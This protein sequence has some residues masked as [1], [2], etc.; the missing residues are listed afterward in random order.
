MSHNQYPLDHSEGSSPDWEA[1]SNMGRKRAQEKEMSRHKSDWRDAGFLTPAAASPVPP[2]APETPRCEKCGEMT[3]TPPVCESCKVAP[4]AVQEEA[5][6]EVD[7]PQCGGVGYWGTDACTLCSGSGSV[8]PFVATL[9]AAPTPGEPTLDV[10]AAR[11]LVERLAFFCNKCGYFGETSEHSNCGYFAVESPAT[12]QLRA[13]LAE[14]ARLTREIAEG[15]PALRER[16]ERMEE[17]L[18]AANRDVARL[19]RERND[20]EEQAQAAYRI[21]KEESAKMERELAGY[22]EV[23]ERQREMMM[24]AKYDARRDKWTISAKDFHDAL[25]ALAS[26]SPTPGDTK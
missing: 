1:L 14:V 2:S 11:K 8:T 23:V 6:S 26:L 12:V 22:R 15:F 13:A 19:T 5:P 10:E 9:A 24:I 17:S 20:T 7:C 18:V 4:S 16:A 25:A 3:W 21:F